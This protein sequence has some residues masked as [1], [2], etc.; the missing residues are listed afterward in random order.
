MSDGP[1]A[2]P[3]HHLWYSALSVPITKTSSRFGPQATASGSP[4]QTPPMRSKPVSD[5]PQAEPFH[6]LWYSAP[7]V[8]ITKTSSRF[9]PQA[10]ARGADMQTPP[11]RS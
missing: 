2:E 6:H 10:T 8:P 4:T 9:G 3:F 11:R 1:Q 5:G 7:S